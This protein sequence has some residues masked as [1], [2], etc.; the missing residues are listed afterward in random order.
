VRAVALLLGVMGVCAATAAADGSTTLRRFANCTDAVAVLAPKKSQI[1]LRVDCWAPGRGGEFGFS[2]ARLD[3]Q[4]NARP[5]GIRHFDRHPAVSGSGAAHS[6]ARCRWWPDGLGCLA[7]SRGRIALHEAIRVRP[8]TRCIRRI[9][10]T[11]SVTTCE[12]TAGESCPA[13][14]TIAQLFSGFPRGC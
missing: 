7:G 8:E 11:T 3:S 6:H 14:L 10:I 1:N 13:S 9:S 2:V 12:P 4:G 5:P